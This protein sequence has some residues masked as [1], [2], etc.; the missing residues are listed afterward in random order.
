METF[1]PVIVAFCLPLLR[2]YRGGYGRQHAPE[3]SG[4]N[5]KIVRVPCTGK[6][7]VIHILRALAKRR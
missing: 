7:D 6:V 3:L 1:E 2:L 5:V 4:P